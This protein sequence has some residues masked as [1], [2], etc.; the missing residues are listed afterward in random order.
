M[1]MTLKI[2]HQPCVQVP[3]NLLSDL[4]PDLPTIP[5]EFSLYYDFLNGDIDFEPHF[6]A[7]CR[8]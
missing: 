2:K 6:G 5:Q 3:C 1:G 8:K 7:F 4:V